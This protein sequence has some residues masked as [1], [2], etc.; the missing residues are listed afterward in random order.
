MVDKLDFEGYATVWLA[1]DPHLK[2]YVAVKISIADSLPRHQC[3]QGLVCTAATVLACTPWAWS[4]S[5]SSGG[6]RGARSEWNTYVVHSGTAE[7]NPRG[8]CSSRLSPSR[9][10]VRYHRGLHRTLHTEPPSMAFP[11]RF[12]AHPTPRLAR[13]VELRI[14]HLMPQAS[15]IAESG[16]HIAR[17]REQ[18]FPWRRN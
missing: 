8:I 17:S 18:P 11:F 4:S 16:A 5:L 15:T 10:L 12:R 6:I 13:Q 3:A 14:P 7:C 9:L 2:T 1:R